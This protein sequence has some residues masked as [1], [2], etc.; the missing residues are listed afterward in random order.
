MTYPILIPSRGRVNDV[1]TVNNMPEKYH[2][3]IILFVPKEELK[4]YRNLHPNLRV[5]TVSDYSHRISE[6]RHR[7]V[8]WIY[9]ELKMPWF[10]MMDD[11]LQFARRIKPDEPKLER[12]GPLDEHHFYHMFDY[13]EDMADRSMDGEF[14]LCTIGIS[15]RQGN[16]NLPPEGADNTR[17]IRCGLYR[18]DAFLGCEHNRIDFMGD[19]DVMLQMLE[20]GYDNHV[21]SRWT[22]DHKATNAVGGCETTRDEETM[23]RVA[24]QLADLHP[25]I[26][27]TKQKKNKTGGLAERT[28]VTIYWKKARAS[29]DA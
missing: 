6:K 10:W 2:K 15:M 19:F 23:N 16:N 11:D 18:T 14:P 17:L 26:V 27:K 24:H 1:A 25:G 20:A 9:H 12:M 22:Q 21:V 13:C 8:K 29:A 28:D 4:V 7:M 3:N 5:A